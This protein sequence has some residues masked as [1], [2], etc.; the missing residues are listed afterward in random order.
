MERLGTVF[1]IQHYSLHDGPGIRTVVFLK[2]CP[3]R[4]LWCSNPESQNPKPELAW[5]RTAC[6]GCQ[7]C[8]RELKSGN[9][10][11]ERE[12]SCPQ[13]ERGRTMQESAAAQRELPRASILRWEEDTRPEDSIV[14]RTCP[15]KALHVMGERKSVDEVLGEVEKDALFYDNTCGGMT[16][17]GG[18]PLSQRE[19]VIALLTEA[20]K[21]RIHCAMETSGYAEWE[22]F[23]SV[24]ER[25]DYL[26][27]DIK[28][29]DEK[30]HEKYTGVSNT[31]ILENFKKLCEEFPN[32][33]IH[34]RTPVIPGVNDNK[35]EIQAIH[36]FLLPFSNVRYELLK[37]HRLGEPKYASLHREYPL[38]K[39]ELTEGAMDLL[40]K[41]EIKPS[42]S[43]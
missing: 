35:E 24:V 31:R 41:F 3:L 26:L 38:G 4:C 12:V 28:C 6:I 39:R 42:G 33:P 1:N 36:D 17:S 43:G 7:C 22:V 14:M 5:N 10:R 9:F 15:T 20:K 18:E 29:M 34:V 40:K 25:L 37:Y 11:F 32:L 16:L 19:F 8:V 13:N 30:I 2:G 27:M 21:R 23:K